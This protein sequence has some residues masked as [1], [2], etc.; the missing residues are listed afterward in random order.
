M[1]EK[2]GPD[3]TR[4]EIMTWMEDSWGESLA[5]GIAEAVEESESEDEGDSE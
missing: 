4:A 5:E 2:P 3:A 1:A